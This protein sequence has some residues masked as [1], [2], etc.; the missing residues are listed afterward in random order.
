MSAVIMYIVMPAAAEALP[1]KLSGDADRRSA[2][3]I[4]IYM[5]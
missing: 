4:D 2:Y 3:D 5:I 1:A